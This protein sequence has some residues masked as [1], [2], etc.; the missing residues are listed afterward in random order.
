MLVST[1]GHGDE[2]DNKITVKINQSD[3]YTRQSDGAES[4]RVRQNDKLQR[5][6]E[7][8]AR[9][10]ASMTKSDFRKL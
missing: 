7:R 6:M 10:S 2:I 1:F 8:Q 4:V 9:N 3:S 5:E